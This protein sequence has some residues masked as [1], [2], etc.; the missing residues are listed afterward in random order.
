M[1]WRVSPWVYTVWDSLCLLDLIDCFLFQYG[2]IFNYNLFKSFLIR[3]LLLFFSC[4]PCNLNLGAFDIVPEVSDTVFSSFHSFNCILLFRSYLH[5][6]IFQ[7]TDLFFCFRYSAF[8]SFYSIFDFSNCVV[9]LCMFIFY[10]S[11]SLL[12]DSCIFCI[13]FLRF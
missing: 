1:S 7:V 3:F 5:C 6:I 8:D 13:L 2:E 9:C 4:D 10:S 11:M 12:I